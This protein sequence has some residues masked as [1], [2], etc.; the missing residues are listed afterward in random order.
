MRSINEISK[1]LLDFNGFQRI[2]TGFQLITDN[3][4]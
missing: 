3:E 1:N 4:K 2:S